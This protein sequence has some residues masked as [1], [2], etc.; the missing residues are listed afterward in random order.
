MKW[1]AIYLALLM[2]LMPMTGFLSEEN[3]VSDEMSVLEGTSNMQM[4]SG[5]QLPDY[6][7]YSPMA[8]SMTGSNALVNGSTMSVAHAPMRI[9]PTSS[10]QWDGFSIEP[11]DGL[12]SELPTFPNNWNSHAMGAHWWN[13]DTP[14]PVSYTHLTLPTIYSV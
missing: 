6:I 10:S 13:F 14:G 1:K 7:L 2:I 11:A 4:S 8:M 12:T 9:P 5:T 3:E